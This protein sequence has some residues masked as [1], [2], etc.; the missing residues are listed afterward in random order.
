MALRV[1]FTRPLGCLLSEAKGIDPEHP[2]CK[3]GASQHGRAPI[4][5]ATFRVRLDPDMAAHVK[6]LK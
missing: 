1:D 5:K 3:R 4:N 2:K 6:R